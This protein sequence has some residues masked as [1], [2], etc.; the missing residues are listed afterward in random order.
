MTSTRRGGSA[1]PT[2]PTPDRAQ[3][4]TRLATAHYTWWVVAMLWL[5]SQGDSMRMQAELHA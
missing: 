4:D 5:I 2:E 1:G 3:R